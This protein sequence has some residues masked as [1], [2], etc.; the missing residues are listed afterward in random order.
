M[1]R[2][3]PPNHG[4]FRKGYNGPMTDSRRKAIGVGSRKAWQTQRDR[5]MLGILKRKVDPL[6]RFRKLFRVL[7]NGCHEWISSKNMN[8]YGSFWDGNG[9]VRA[10]RFAYEATNGSIP[11]GLTIDH[12]C[13]NRACVNAEHLRLLTQCE[14]WSI[15]T[16]PSAVN[17]TKQSCKYGHPLSGNNLRVRILKSGSVRRDCLICTRKRGRET[18]RRWRERRKAAQS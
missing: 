9:T 5:M 12:I 14:N 1:P 8:G 11:P 3:C 15:G 13:R 16:A 10:H 17:A 6:V 4:Q 7:D 2:G 18:R